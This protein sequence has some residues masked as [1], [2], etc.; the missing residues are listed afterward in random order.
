MGSRGKAWEGMGWRPLNASQAKED[1]ST[2]RQHGSSTLRDPCTASSAAARCLRTVGH[3]L[4]GAHQ[5]ASLGQPRPWLPQQRGR[6]EALRQVTAAAGGGAGGLAGGPALRRCRRCCCLHNGCVLRHIFLQGLLRGHGGGSRGGLLHAELR[7][8][9]GA[10]LLGGSQGLGCWW[11]PG[12]SAMMQH[13]PPAARGAQAGAEQAWNPCLAHGSANTALTQQPCGTGRR[14]A[15]AA[16]MQP[17]ANAAR[18]RLR[19]PV[20][21]RCHVRRGPPGTAPS[22]V[23]ISMLSFLD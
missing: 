7:E 1:H 20:G 6:A 14:S 9:V 4:R 18:T 12:G 21:S 13:L 23:S 5:L 2:R 16:P 10:G 3:R 11:E 19:M 15:S 8:G 17:S 22:L